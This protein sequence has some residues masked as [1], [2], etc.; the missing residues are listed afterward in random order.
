MMDAEL[1]SDHPPRDGR[2]AR[3]ASEFRQLSLVLMCA[4]AALIA[5]Y[6]GGNIGESISWATLVGYFSIMLLAFV[7]AAGLLRVVNMLIFRRLI[8]DRDKQSQTLSEE[9]RHLLKERSPEIE[10]RATEVD[11]AALIDK[12]L[13]ERGS[14]ASK[15][16]PESQADG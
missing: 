5:G 7:V 1:N 13:R 3:H 9:I 10:F 16:D 6:I 4:G 11:V 14:L 12:V 15:S 8:S 2:A